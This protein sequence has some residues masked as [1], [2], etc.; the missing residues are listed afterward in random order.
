[1]PLI[2][3]ISESEWKVMKVIW[4]SPEPLPSYD[5]IQA[6]RDERWQPRTIKTLLNRLVKKKALDYHKYKNLY[7]YYAIVSETECL[8]AESDSFLER[9]FAGSLQPM[10]AHFVEQ[11]ELTREEI[12]Q[13]IRIL[14]EKR[15]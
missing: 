15:R 9:C 14:D 5:V 12:K 8:K 1:M 10:L 11:R 2:P 7:L 4:A 3:R 13:L 6:L